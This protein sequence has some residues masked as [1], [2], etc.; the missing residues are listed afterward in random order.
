M[1]GFFF[2]GFLNAKQPYTKPAL[3]I[4]QQIAQLRNRGMVISDTPLAEHYLSQINYYRLTAYW[5][6]L[7]LITPHMPSSLEPALSK[8]WTCT[9][10]I[11]NYA[12]W[13]LILLSASKLPYAR[14]GFPVGA[15]LRHTPSFE[16]CVIQ[17]SLGS[18]QECQPIAKRHTAKQR[19]LHPAPVG[20]ICRTIAAIWAAVE[21]MTLGQLSQVVCQP[22]KRR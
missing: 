9:S 17:A 7:S 13:Y 1:R 8:S 10:L 19:S 20:E 5:L 6:P 2:M 16:S 11:V 22:K 4:D 3:T 14:N 21:V 12:C 15:S 18:H